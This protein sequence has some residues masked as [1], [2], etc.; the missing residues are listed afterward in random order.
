VI[1]T[2][3]TRTG[4]VPPGD[5]VSRRGSSARALRA[6]ATLLL[7]VSLLLVGSGCER[8]VPENTVTLYLTGAQRQAETL[9][10]RQEIQRA[11]RDMLELPPEQLRDK[12]YAN[13][14]MEPGS[15][16]AIDILERYYFPESPLTMLVPETFY[17]D[18]ALPPAREAIQRHL[19]RITK[20]IE[21]ETRA[22][23][24]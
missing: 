13:Y 20:D 4:R 6:T 2:L 7:G 14:Q 24:P 19:D 22:G 9:D 21:A 18:V 1:P 17:R 23:A 16:T 11:L 5:P 8:N 15:W 12:R 3:A 10:Q